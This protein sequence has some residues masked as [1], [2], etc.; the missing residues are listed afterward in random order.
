MQ[1]QNA[2]LEHLVSKRTRDLET[3]TTE[4]QSSQD[5]TIVALGS[6]AETRD[7]ETGNHIHR[8]R[9]Y[10]E[11]LARLLG[12]T[13]K[14]SAIARTKDWEMIWKFAPLHDIGKVGIPDSILLK[15]GSLT[16]EEFNVMKRHTVLGRDALRLAEDRVDMYGAFFRIAMEIAYSHH[17]RW[18]GSGYPEG[19]SGEAIPLAARLMAVA[20]VYDALISKRVY[21]EAMPHETAVDII[22]GESGK[23][24]DPRVVDC[25]IEAADEFR[26]IASRFSDA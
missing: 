1:D 26:I 19:L 5:L 15:P 13:A 8:T 10:V 16:A 21:K 20:D 22:C 6:I 25:F 9:A 7:N 3:K 17:E 12:K 18:N 14:F 2:H 4:L 11:V 24:F 23:H